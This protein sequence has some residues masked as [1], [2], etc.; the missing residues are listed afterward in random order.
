LGTL[1]RNPITG[2]L[3]SCAYQI[4]IQRRFRLVDRR[5]IRIVRTRHAPLEC[6]NLPEVIIDRRYEGIPGVSLGGY[7]AGVAA[8]ELGG[9]VTVTL[10][11]IV[12][13]GS[14]LT[15]ERNGSEVRLHIA[16]ELAATA[17]ESPF[18]TTAPQPV[19]AHEAEV[20]SARYPGFTHHFFPN[21]FTCGPSRSVGEGLRIFPGPV[22]GRQV[23]A[24]LWNPPTLCWQA[25]ETVASEFLWAALDC[26]AIW[27]HIVHGA[28]QPD[29]RAVTGRL[30]LLQ[31]APVPGKRA[32][33]VLGWPIARDGRKV[34][35][36]AAIF[37]Q[38]GNLLV[39]ARQTM[40][41]T[42]RGVPLHADA[43]S[44]QWS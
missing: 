18:E 37:S 20:A 6:L 8:K 1:N 43:W 23:V 40:I 16:D 4:G 44:H 14:T 13:P 29:D 10:A 30:A 32:S 5:P 35:A 15:L 25:D 17:V 7:V 9:S 39:E 12:E 42:D 24:A 26:P 34:I 2:H 3:E 33:I 21:C 27:G 41:L 28:A 19:T 11:R 38:A 31:R 22:D 36:G